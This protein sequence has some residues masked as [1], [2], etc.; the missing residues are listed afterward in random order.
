[1]LL[2]VKCCRKKQGEPCSFQGCT[3]VRNLLDHYR[4]CREMRIIAIAQQKSGQTC[5]SVS[6]SN[7][8]AVRRPPT[9]LV[10]SIMARHVRGVLENGPT[11]APVPLVVKMPQLQHEHVQTSNKRNTVPTPTK[12]TLQRVDSAV[13]MPPPP[14]RRPRSTSAPNL[15]E[16]RS[17]NVP[18]VMMNNMSTSSSST[19]SH[20][21]KQRHS[22]SLSYT[23][24]HRGRSSSDGMLCDLAAEPCET[25]LEEPAES[26]SV[27]I[28]GL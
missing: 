26:T 3:Q 6:S 10:C 9:C 25:I 17:Q 2:H 8:A 16:A 20:Q 19:T 21:H 28:G 27:V 23:S 4:K 15:Q 18:M 22:S 12:T 14:P 7:E 5:R 24:L 13:I 1:M 11:H